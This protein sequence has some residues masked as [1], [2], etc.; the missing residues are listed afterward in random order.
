MKKLLLSALLMLCMSAFAQ[1]QYTLQSPDGKITVTVS[2]DEICEMNSERSEYCL[3]YSVKHEETVVLDNSGI[4]MHIDNGKI[5]GISSKPSII[6]AKTKS[7][8]QT[9]KA[10]F[11]K[12][13][14]IQDQY[15]EL[16]LSFKGNYKVIFRAYNEGVALMR[17]TRH[18]CLMSTPAKAMAT[19]SNSSFTILLKTPIPSRH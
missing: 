3:Y 12:R 10:P 7:V 4:A 19:S 8:D 1:K 11:Y 15:N 17:I 13:A 16:T 18:G 5:L 14:E 2:E 6:S 9:V